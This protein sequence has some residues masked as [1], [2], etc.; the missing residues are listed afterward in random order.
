MLSFF[1]RLSKSKIGTGIMAA[2]LI[3]ILAGFALAD[4]SNFGTG[5]LGF[6]LD[7]STIAKIGREKI[8]DREMRDAMQR[9]L[10]QVREQNP[11]ADYPSLAKDF[12]PL[13]SQMIDQRAIIAFANKHGFPISKRLVDAEISDLP[14]VRG[15]NGQPSVQGYQMF[16]AQNRLTDKQVRELLSAE[17]VARYL[18]LPMSAAGPAIRR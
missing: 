7:S 10:Q 5:S 1:R 2:V 13:L 16:L 8:T 15:L 4:L 14:N 3:A 11:N 18:L 6:G 17:I 12:D 9:R